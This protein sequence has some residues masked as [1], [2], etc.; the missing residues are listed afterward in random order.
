MAYLL[1]L[2]GQRQGRDLPLDRDLLHF[3]R[4]EANDFI[5]EDPSVS[6]RHCTIIRHEDHYVIRDLDSSNGTRVNDHEV[7]ESKIE[8]GDIIEM[9]SLLFRF[10]ASTVAV[11][12]KATQVSAVGDPFSDEKE[13]PEPPAGKEP[14][15]SDPIDQEEALELPQPSKPDEVPPRPEAS[16]AHAPSSAALPS[17]R[18]PVDLSRRSMSYTV[19]AVGG[20][21]VLTISI[22]VYLNLV[23][24]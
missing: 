12:E 2:N 3:G 23:M 21:I 14:A 16:S 15:P 13:A 18:L 6:G 22:V 7:S 10:M 19:I 17:G 20:L 1:G 5:L 24:S 11:S 4:S 8:S 9:G